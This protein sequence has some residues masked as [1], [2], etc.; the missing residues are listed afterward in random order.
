MTLG[1]LRRHLV[2]APKHT[3]AVHTKH[4]FALNLSRH[5]L[6][7]NPVL[8]LSRLSRL[9]RS[10]GRLHDGPFGDGG[11][12]VAE[13]IC[14]MSWNELGSCWNELEWPSLEARREQS[15]LTSFYKIH[16]DIVSLNKIDT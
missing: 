13:V 14:L 12:K 9:R 7:G 2:F 6:F 4:C 5:H 15:S 10:R 16:S 11:I 8:K 3:Q 1:F